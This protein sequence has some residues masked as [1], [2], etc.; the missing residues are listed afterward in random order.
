[1]IDRRHFQRQGIATMLACLF[2]LKQRVSAE[3]PE[4]RRDLDEEYTAEVDA[5]IR[6]G[7]RG[8][9]AALRSDFLNRPAQ[10]R[11]P[12][13]VGLVG[14]AMLSAGGQ[15]DRPPLGESLGL[16]IDYVLNRAEESG[17]IHDSQSRNYGP[18]YEHGFG[19]LL[20]AECYGASVRNDIRPVIE[21]AL[22]V[23]FRSQNDRG[24]WRY[25]PVPN[26]ADLSVTVCQMMAMRAA[27]NAG[28]FVPADTI[29]RA[30]DYV[31]RCQNADG[32]FAYQ[33]TG[34]P[35][36]WPLTAAA[37]VALQN[38]GNYA[39]PEIDRAYEYLSQHRREVAT[40]TTS[41]YFFYAHYYA[42]QAY[43][44]RGGKTFQDWYRDIR[45]TLLRLQDADGMWLDT[46]GKVY[47]T[48]M[49]C[50]ILSVPRSILPI[51]QK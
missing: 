39:G 22:E 41:N 51:F 19:T 48:A 42:I 45:N 24:G 16:V 38:A 9:E 32:G 36:R 29:R 3:P 26:D 27:R 37:I 25:H 8:I 15:P 10:G 7:L 11:N 14:L 34:G 18:M 5:A 30:V 4:A 13:V 35:S 2:A 21:H 50:L 49:A 1:M 28:L 43:W 44:Q 33:I 46:V 12:G 31:K 20:L 23:I 47:G 17:F 40:P 6:R